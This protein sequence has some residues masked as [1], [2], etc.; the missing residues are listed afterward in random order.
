MEYSNY[1]GNVYKNIDEYNPNKK[2]KISLVFDNMIADMLS[3]KNDNPVV[4]EIFMKGKV[5]T[6]YLVFNSQSYFPLPK[7]Y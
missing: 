7:K 6:I 5:L 4:T 3:T 2:Q 1:M